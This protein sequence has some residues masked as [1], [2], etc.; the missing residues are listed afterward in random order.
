M[1]TK[2]ENRKTVVEL[3]EELGLEMEVPKVGEK[4]SDYWAGLVSDLKAKKRDANRETD[5]DAAK[6]KAPEAPKVPE[7]PVETGGSFVIKAG[8]SLTSLKGIL[9]PGVEVKPEFFI[10]GQETLDKH[11]KNGYIVKAK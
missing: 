9:G 4:N 3:V 7:A 11:K 1:P 2:K 6:E 10:G 8:C 5:A